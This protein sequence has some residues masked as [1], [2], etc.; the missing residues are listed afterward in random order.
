[1]DVRPVRRRGLSVP[2]SADLVP[3]NLRL[4]DTGR[5]ADD[6]GRAAPR[7]GGGSYISGSI[8]AAC[9]PLPPCRRGVNIYITRA[10]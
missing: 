8:F 5:R 2:T 9:A 6:W 7:S 4:R 1:M 10:A 3:L